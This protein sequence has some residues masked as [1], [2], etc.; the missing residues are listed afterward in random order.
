MSLPGLRR[1]LAVVAGSATLFVVLGGVAHTPVGRPLLRL[2]GKC[3][4]GLPGSLP[5]AE[6]EA[7]RSLAIQRLRGTTPAATRPALGFVLGQTKRA[8]VDAWAAGQSLRCDPTKTGST[9]A[10][11]KVPVALL[12]E[13]FRGA[14]VDELTF[15]FDASNVLVAIVTRRG[16]LEPKIAFETQREIA[17]ALDAGAG[18]SFSRTGDERTL[19][20]VS[21]FS[22]VRNEWRFR[23]YYASC[24]ASRINQNIT[25]YEEYM[26][27][28]D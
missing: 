18:P 9:L 16:Q 7:G 5:P 27:I 11:P 10:C 22:Q 1:A 23:D 4:V 20:A 13:R 6:R 14:P 12:P 19:D 28:P 2:L 26:L 15:R 17:S 21:A 8:D 24:T 3:P 25:L